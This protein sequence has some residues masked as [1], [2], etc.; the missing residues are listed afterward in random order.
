MYSYNKHIQVCPFESPHGTLSK[1]TMTYLLFCLLCSA[2]VGRTGTFIAIDM[3]LA[4][5]E[6]EGVVDICNIIVEMR[7]QRMKMVQTVVSVTSK[8]PFFLC[9]NL[10]T[11]VDVLKYCFYCLLTL[12]PIYFHMRCHPWVHHLWQHSDPGCWLATQPEQAT[13]CR[14]S[15]WKDR[16]PATVWCECFWQ[17]SKQTGWSYDL[18]VVGLSRCWPKCHQT[19]MKSRVPLLL[20]IPT[21]IEHFSMHLVSY[22]ITRLVLCQSCYVAHCIVH[23]LLSFSW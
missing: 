20:S 13:L 12:G 14:S 15:N 17:V 3:A 9:S 8:T 11:I 7:Q 22:I 2:G 1:L 16:L 23:S 18:F 4:K 10:F 6:A 5:V 19:R 21:A